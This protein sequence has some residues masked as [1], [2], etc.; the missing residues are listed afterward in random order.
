MVGAPR[1]TPRGQRG[2]RSPGNTLM[3]LVAPD[4]QPLF[5]Y[6]TARQHV[7]TGPFPLPRP[8]FPQQ[9]RCRESLGA[10]G[11]SHPTLILS[12]SSEGRAEVW[13]EGLLNVEPICLQ[14]GPGGLLILGTRTGMRVLIYT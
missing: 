2:D 9:E 11:K 1:E 3:A 14:G 13:A 4:T 12:L 5:L 6:Q 10:P 8:P 7:G